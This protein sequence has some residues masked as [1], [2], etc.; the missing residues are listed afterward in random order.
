MKKLAVI[1]L[2]FV[3]YFQKGYAQAAIVNDPLNYA[4]LSLVIEDGLEQTENLKKSWE[5]MKATKDAVDKV[6]SVVKTVEDI[7]RVVNLS[8]QLYTTSSNLIERTKTL[9]GC[10]PK[11]INSNIRLC[12]RYN[13]RILDIVN[14]L[15]SL[16]TDNT[17]KL[18]DYERV[19]MVREEIDELSKLSVL[20]DRQ[21]R[22]VER[23]NDTMQLFN[24]F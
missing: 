21:Q 24:L 12:L 13:V 11:Y 7:E 19:K 14:R 16:L 6:S 22:S 17:F 15:T 23:V 5:I 2:L 4:Q 8:S 3:L 18:N 1:L 10:D 20:L 9:K